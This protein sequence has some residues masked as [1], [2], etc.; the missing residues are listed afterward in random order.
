MVCA[1]KPLV[2]S[3]IFPANILYD[4]QSKSMGGQ[5][6]VRFLFGSL[7]VNLF[8]QKYDWKLLLGKAQIP[9]ICLLRCNFG[10]LSDMTEKTG[11]SL[12][13]GFICAGWRI[14]HLGF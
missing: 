10:H 3:V 1:V 11:D 12:Y 5:G 6:I 4:R 8:F 2:S 9:D 14:L 13:R 7:M